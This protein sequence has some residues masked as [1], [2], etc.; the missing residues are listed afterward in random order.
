MP[1]APVM[2]RPRHPKAMPALVLGGL[3]W[4]LG[5]PLIFSIP[6]WILGA[7]AR[8]EIEANPHLYD[9]KSEATAGMWLGAV[10]TMLMAL[11]LL[12]VLAVFVFLP[13][14]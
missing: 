5:I 7:A 2:A 1:M 3:S 12:A 6:A 4:F 8:R 14:H 10:H 11:A 9:G 13:S